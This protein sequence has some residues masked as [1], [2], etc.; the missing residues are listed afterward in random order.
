VT[1]IDGW[2]NCVTSDGKQNVTVL[3]GYLGQL[4]IVLNALAKFFPSIDRPPVTPANEENKDKTSPSNKNEPASKPESATLSKS[5]SMDAIPA[6]DRMFFNPPTIQSFIYNYIGEKLKTDRIQLLVDHRFENFLNSLPVPLPINEM[7]TLKELNYNKMRALLTKHVGNPVLETIRR[8]Q[9][10][11][12]LDEDI[13]GLVYEGFWD[14]YTLKSQTGTSAKKLQQWIQKI[15]LQTTRKPEGYEVEEAQEE[16]DEEG[17]PIQKPSVMR[18]YEN[19]PTDPV[20]P[21]DAL[22]RL[23]IPKKQAEAEFDE[24]G[25]EIPHSVDESDLEEVA[26]ED[27]CATIDTIGETQKIWAINQQADR[28]IRNDL[29]AEL[30]SFSPKLDQFDLK[31]LEQAVENEA[32]RFEK[33]FVDLFVEDDT[34]E[35]KV[36]VFDFCPL[37]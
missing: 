7:R 25:V 2:A 18:D 14:L 12:G 19:E 1:D 11:L 35:F 30:K 24:D 16:V 20:Q 32:V 17:N 29:I 5:P 34:N 36:P 21:I 31:E 22:V 8:N 27:K 33:E 10:T 3:G 9:D 13:F 6:H 28:A 26:F 37:L 4:M 23:R 15:N